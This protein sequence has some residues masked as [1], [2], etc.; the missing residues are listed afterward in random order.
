MSAWGSLE[1]QKCGK[2]RFSG[3]IIALS[4]FYSRVAQDKIVARLKPCPSG[5]TFSAFSLALVA[6]DRGS[7][8]HDGC[9]GNKPCC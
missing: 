7:E 4:G 9:E 2:M 3:E 8:N 6:R 5:K 1:L